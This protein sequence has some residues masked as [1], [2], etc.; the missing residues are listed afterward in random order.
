MAR[1]AAHARPAGGGARRASS[2]LDCPSHAPPGAAPATSPARGVLGAHFASARAHGRGEPLFSTTPPPPLTRGAA[3]PV[4]EAVCHHS[5]ARG[6]PGKNRPTEPSAV[7]AR[8]IWAGRPHGGRFGAP[9]LSDPHAARLEARTPLP[10]ARA[11]G[12]RR[13]G[14]Q[15]RR[16]SARAPP[17]APARHRRSARGGCGH[18]VAP[19]RRHPPA[20]PVAAAARRP[21]RRQRRLQRADASY[22]WLVPAWDA[23]GAPPT[24][25]TQVPVPPL[26]V[27][28]RGVGGVVC[29][30]RLRVHG[31]RASVVFLGGGR[32][33]R[34]LGR[35]RQRGSSSTRARPV[36]TSA[37]A[38]AAH[39]G[40]APTAHRTAVS[41]QASALF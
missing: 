28:A 27:E 8:H 2:Q 16:L 17:A 36:A 34:R 32:R 33:R 7:P 5:T 13:R 10:R 11:D 9:P 37:A 20:V 15:S 12:P 26:A 30:R 3:R 35:R 25:P 41:A 19:S 6:W 18:T 39:G 29:H 22:L 38:A 24:L 31:R 23:A 14:G 40:I 1:A 21:H 4:P